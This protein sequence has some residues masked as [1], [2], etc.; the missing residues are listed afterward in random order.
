MFCFSFILTFGTAVVLAPL[1]RISPPR[2][3]SRSA[4]GALLAATLAEA[5]EE[6][7]SLL[8][9]RLMLSTLADP[10]DWSTDPRILNPD[11]LMH[12]EDEPEVGT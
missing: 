6:G 3:D 7:G 8:M 11:K 9:T 12:T 10:L 2:S 4:G 5:E 1:Q